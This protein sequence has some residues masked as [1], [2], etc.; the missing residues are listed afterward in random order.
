MIEDRFPNG[1]P[2][3]ELAGV[4]MT[5]HE[6]VSLADRM[7]VT[8]C[9]NPL[10]TALAVTGCMLG[11]DSIWR[12]MEDGVLSALVRRIGEEGMAV[13]R[14]PGILDP[15]A[16]LREF[17]DERLPNP[18]IPD[19]PQRIACDTSQKVAIRYGETIKA[20]LAGGK[21]LDALTGIPLAIASWLRYLLAVDDQTR[22]MACS[23][24]PRLEALQRQLSGV[25]VGR[26]DSYA[27]Q[28][29]PILADTSIF[30]V[31]LTKTPMATTIESHFISMLRGK[32]AVRDTLA[33][34]LKRL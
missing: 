24:D 7:K 21:S 31:D 11:Y 23:P 18:N 15:R 25:E 20:Y 22:P 27:S 9:L 16:F 32:S 8:V 29:R 10:H 33:K 4:H 2:P 28:L 12:E 3:L 30:G 14:H 5:D 6:T 17:L 26:P 13:V 19:T 34:T 1:R